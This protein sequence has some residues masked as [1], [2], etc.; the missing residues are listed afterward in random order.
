MRILILGKIKGMWPQALFGPIVPYVLEIKKWQAILS[1]GFIFLFYKFKKQKIIFINDLFCQIV[2][3]LPAKIFG[4]KIFWIG[5]Y[6]NYG[7]IISLLLK[8]NSLFVYK[9]VCSNQN[10][11]NL[12]LK[13]GISDKKLELVYPSSQHLFK[14]KDYQKKTEDIIIACDGDMGMEEGLSVFLKAVSLARDIVGNL[15]IIIGGQVLEKQ[16]IYW[17]SQRLK[18]ST[19]I[20]PSAGFSWPLDCA[21]FVAPTTK[22][23]FVSLSLL[24][25]MSMGKAVVATKTKNNGEFI[26]A[27]K[28][29]II[30]EPNNSEMLSQAIINLVRREEWRSDLGQAA[31]KFVKDKFSK[32]IFE[33]KIGKLLN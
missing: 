30:V 25:A 7:K 3:S 18:L 1:L 24:G 21:I 31:Q 4:Y 26:I 32:N 28:N 23:S 12:Y 9:V 22:E 19:Q 2:F 13:A 27:N 17:L 29:G 5:G 6:Q 14:K 10:I 33:Q 16:K 15:K 20:V 8:I 11:E